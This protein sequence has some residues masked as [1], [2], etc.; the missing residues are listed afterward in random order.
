MTKPT[1]HSYETS[2]PCIDAHIFVSSKHHV[3]K[4]GKKP[5]GANNSKNEKT[6]IHGYLVHHDTGIRVDD[7]PD[8]RTTSKPIATNVKRSIKYVIGRLVRWYIAFNANSTSSIE[9]H[10]KI[11]TNAFDSIKDKSIFRAGKNWLPSTFQ[12]YIGYFKNSV[13]P[14]MD[15]Y[16]ITI[17]Q[18]NLDAIQRE[19]I[20][21]AAENGDKDRLKAEKGVRTKLEHANSFL[22]IIYNIIGGVAI[23]R[24]FFDLPPRSHTNTTEQIKALPIGLRVTL[25]FVLLLVPVNICPVS[26]GVAL[27]FYCGLRTAEAAAPTFKE[28][29]HHKNNGKEFGSYYVQYQYKGKELVPPKSI[30]AYRQVII[31]RILMYKLN[32]R[33]DYLEKQGLSSAEIGDMPVVS[34]HDDAKR[35]AGPDAIS[36]FA[37]K[38]LEKCGFHISDALI[39]LMMEEPML[40]ADDHPILEPHAYML[41]RDWTSRMFN[42]N[43]I[44]RD[45]IDYLI[46]HKNEAR[47]ETI[48]SMNEDKLAEIA[49]MYE[50]FVAVPEFS[51]HPLY[52]PIIINETFDR[53]DIPAH[54][55]FSIKADPS[56]D[57][58]VKLQLNLS[59]TEPIV[60]IDIQSSCDISDIKVS[61]VSTGNILSDGIYKH[62]IIAPPYSNEIYEACRLKAQEI[63]SGGDII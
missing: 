24:P 15:Q 52:N 39:T 61:Q 32:Q 48:I 5:V 33:K 55:A 12:E 2:I 36:A 40:D 57:H 18:S 29:A 47:S 63:I 51:Y 54:C 41:R 21:R 4:K 25:A 38:L 13:L 3:D 53:A 28:I 49:E 62:T 46:G 58:P 8:V 60:S 1:K 16:G 22:R 23:S 50:R 35:Y 9:P 6:L 37:K 31:P 59:C 27:M 42:V 10:D 26:L 20:E 11:F 30:N 56:L 43:G 19:L 7:S 44:D 45:I 17:T 14:K 34:R